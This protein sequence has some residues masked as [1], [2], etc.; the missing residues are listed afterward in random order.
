MQQEEE[1]FDIKMI[2]EEENILQIGAESELD[3]VIDMF[4]ENVVDMREEKKDA[5]SIAWKDVELDLETI[6]M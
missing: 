5:V 2:I 3:S 4:E 1:G 6:D